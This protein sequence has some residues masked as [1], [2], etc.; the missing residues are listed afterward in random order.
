MKR[1][2]KTLPFMSTLAWAHCMLS[3]YCKCG[4]ATPIW[5]LFRARFSPDVAALHSPT[6]RHQTHHSCCFASLS[7]PMISPLAQLASNKMMEIATQ[8]RRDCG[9]KW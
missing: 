4:K 3:W 8:R 2:K 7:F 6:W 1:N 9:V 5:N